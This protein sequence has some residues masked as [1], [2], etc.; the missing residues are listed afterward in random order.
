MSTI[1]KTFP[2]ALPESFPYTVVQSND[3]YW[4]TRASKLVGIRDGTGAR[5]EPWTGYANWIGGVFDRKEH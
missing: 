4:R 2:Q 1:S 3:Q 5:S